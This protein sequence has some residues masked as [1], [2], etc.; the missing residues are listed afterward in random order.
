MSG[1]ATDA[2][3]RR[4]GLAAV[5]D[6]VTD[7]WASRP[8]RVKRGRKLAGIAA[9]IGRRYGIDPVVVRVALVAATVFGGVGLLVY[10][11]AW[12]LF[13]D[14]HD[15]VSPV[16]ALFGRGRSSTSKA[17]TVVLGLALIPLV[18]GTFGGIGFDGGSFLG[19]GLLLLGLYLLHRGRGHLNRPVSPAVERG[20]AAFS[21]S[22]S[23]EG[24]T[25]T[26]AKD[27]PGA[28]DPLGAAPFAWDLPDPAQPP[29][30]PSP[31]PEPPVVRRQRSKVT[32]ATV[33]VAVTIAGVLTVLGITLGGWFTAPHIIGVTL[34]VLGVGLVA[35]A[36]SG[37]ARGLVGWAIPLSIA[38]VALTAI[39]FHEIPGG[40]GNLDARPLT[41]AEVRPVYEHAFGDIDVDLTALPA[42]AVVSTRVH[43]GAGSNTVIVPATADV[44][45][46]CES[47][48]GDVECLGRETSGVGND[49][50]T[51]FDAGEPGGPVIT[52]D[53]SSSAGSVQVRRG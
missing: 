43:S 3:K 35:G 45:F 47:K 18:T 27:A 32:A 24:T 46:T 21:L 29:P 22:D 16:E 36:F 13:P 52:V 9:G 40:V 37:G 41:A 6:T 48:V 30:V 49:P 10:V 39:P 33:A 4:G 8:R 44:T 19:L 20:P 50:V 38:G 7:F 15:E 25:V 17:F 1:A 51:G 42:D 53:V 26:T 28:W 31:Q 34:G 14:E 12:L 23:D 2:S 11:L 5:E